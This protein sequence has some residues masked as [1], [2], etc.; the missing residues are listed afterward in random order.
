MREMDKLRFPFILTLSFPY[1]LILAY[2][3]VFLGQSPAFRLPW[4]GELGF[5]SSQI[6]QTFGG[7]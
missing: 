2:G 3:V 4:E 6:L 7:A 1:G 5:A